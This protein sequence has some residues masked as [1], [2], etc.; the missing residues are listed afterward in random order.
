MCFLAHRHLADQ[1]RHETATLVCA[2][3]KTR[4]HTPPTNGG[5]QVRVSSPTRGRSTLI[6]SAP[7]SARVCCAMRQRCSH[8]LCVGAAVPS[9]TLGRPECGINP[10]HAC[11]VVGLRTSHVAW[12]HERGCAT[13]LTHTAGK[14]AAPCTLAVHSLEAALTTT[15]T[16]DCG[17][18]NALKLIE[19][20]LRNIVAA[21]DAW[22]LVHASEQ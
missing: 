5:P 2:R 20:R 18:R 9:Y 6:T 4:V 16:Q 22:C 11:L 21:A 19:A 17:A 13:A 12:R 10:A 15:E 7:K 14:R 3:T 1:R 8:K